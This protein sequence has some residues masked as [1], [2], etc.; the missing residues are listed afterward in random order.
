[1]FIFGVDIDFD[2]ILW[3]FHFIEMAA[4]SQLET[5]ALYLGIEEFGNNFDAIKVS[6]LSI[7]MNFGT[8]LFVHVVA[9]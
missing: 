1:L 5:N 7:R 8:G 4:W 6:R 9:R 2:Y 3:C